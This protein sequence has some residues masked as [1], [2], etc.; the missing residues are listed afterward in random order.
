MNRLGSTGWCLFRI[1]YQEEKDLDE[2]S[3]TGAKRVRPGL[4]PKDKGLS[5]PERVDRGPYSRVCT[6]ESGVRIQSR[7]PFRERGKPVE[8]GSTARALVR[9]TGPLPVK[10]E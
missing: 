5:R 3:R 9:V 1:R 6:R 4:I 7:H 8:V 10:Q 2:E